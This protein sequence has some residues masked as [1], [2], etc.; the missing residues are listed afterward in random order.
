MLPMIITISHSSWHPFI[1][2]I[3]LCPPRSFSRKVSLAAF[4]I[5]ENRGLERL[6]DLPKIMQ[7]VHRHLNAQSQVL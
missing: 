4:Y 1:D 2:I 5:R 7:F 3:L 6:N